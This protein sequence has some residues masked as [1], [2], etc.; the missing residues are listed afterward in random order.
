MEHSKVQQ[1]PQLEWP[2]PEKIQREGLRTQMYEK[3]PRFSRFVTLPLV[4]LGKKNLHPS[5]SCQ[6]VL[7]PLEITRPK[8]KTP[9][10][11]T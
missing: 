4:I 5:K 11:S 3:I 6:I 1:S 10:N 9:E 8:T 2:V 7:Y